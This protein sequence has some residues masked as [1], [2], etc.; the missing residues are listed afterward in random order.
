[1]RRK[2]FIQVFVALCLIAGGVALIGI[3]ILGW[4]LQ[5]LAGWWTLLVM[6]AAVA[7]IVRHGPRFWNCFM[8]GGA[9]LTLLYRQLLFIDTPEKYW[10]SMGALALIALGISIIARLIRPRPQ[11]RPP[12]PAGRTIPGRNDQPVRFALFDDQSYSSD[13]KQLRGGRFSTCFGNIAVDLSRAEFGQ[14]VTIHANAV[15]GN[16]DIRTPEHVR[17]ECIGSSLFGGCDAREATMRQYDAEHP[18]LTIN[19]RVVFGN[20]K[21]K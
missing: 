17:V 1:M 12:G 19:Y 20:V 4:D 2:I 10:G 9:V 16:V 3:N 8:L 6:A 14:P 5:R 7:F 15:F 13:C 18:A 21:V 11:P